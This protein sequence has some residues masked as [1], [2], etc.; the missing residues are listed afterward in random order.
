MKIVMY[1]KV[2]LKLSG[3]ALAGDDKIG[4]NQKTIDEICDAIKEIHELGTEVAIVV[5]GGN[6]WRGTYGPDMVKATA[7]YMGMLATAMNALALQDAIE[8]RGLSVRVQTA[9]EMR[10]IA[11]P[12]TLRR[13]ERHINKRRVLIFACGTGSPYFS[14]DTAAALRAAQIGAEAILV[15]KTIDGVYSADPKVDPNAIKYDHITF[16]KVLEDNLKVMDSTAMS[17]CKDNDIPLVVFA[18]SD[19]KNIVRAVKE[20]N[21]GTRVDNNK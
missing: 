20:E 16:Q 10:Q 13:A 8:K 6:F 19:T 3:E 9:I 18:M 15:A 21:I 11:E 17:L 1:K 14:T 12:F 5:G 2:L 7:D 4:L